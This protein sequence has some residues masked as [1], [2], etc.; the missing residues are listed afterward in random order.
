MKK[1]I[2]NKLMTLALVGALLVPSVQTQAASKAATAK[3]ALV[4]KAEKIAIADA[5]KRSVIPIEYGLVDIN[6]DKITEMVTAQGANTYT[7]T[8]YCYASKKVKKLATVKDAY[9]VY[10]DTKGKKIIVESGNSDTGAMAYTEY[11]MN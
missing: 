1:N 9:A 4:A 8:I 7:L 6:G 2:F 3:K 10:K 5:N 11:T